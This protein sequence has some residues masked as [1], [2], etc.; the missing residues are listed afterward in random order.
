MKRIISKIDPEDVC[1]LIFAFA[2]LAACV[3]A[4]IEERSKA[5]ARARFEICPLCEQR[6]KAK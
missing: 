3:A 2:I 5:E 6:V 4:V 1:L